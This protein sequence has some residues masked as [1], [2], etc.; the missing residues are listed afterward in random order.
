MID[1]TTRPEPCHLA[2][3]ALCW[4]RAGGDVLQGAVNAGQLYGADSRAAQYLQTR[5]ASAAGSTTNWGAELAR[6]PA[7]ESTQLIELARRFSGFEQMFGFMRRVDFNA[8][9]AAERVGPVVSWTG[10]AVPKAFS[11]MALETLTGLKPLKLSGGVVHTAELQRSSPTAEAGAARA[12]RN[13][14]AETEDAAFFGTAAAVSGVSAAGI[15][16]GV[17]GIA[18]TDDPAEDIAVLLANFGGDLRTAFLVMPPNIA[19]QLA[20]RGGIFADV[21][22]RG[23]GVIGGLPVIVT[24]G[25]TNDTSG[26]SIGLV[27]AARVCVA[28]S[29]VFIDMSREGALEMT[30]ATTNPPVAATVLVSLWQHNL[31]GLKVERFINWQ[32]ASDDAVALI[33]GASYGSAPAAFAQ[34]VTAGPA[35]RVSEAQ[36][37]A[38]KKGKPAPGR[39]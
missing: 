33:T 2:R 29:D 17:T 16:S 18:S 1:L 20:L 28:A 31:I 13:T 6:P 15:F 3:V 39:K 8:V 4:G 25:I 38:A 21:S 7:V 32:L 36:V 10:E 22:V 23:G 30:D 5:A 14:L 37:A 26:G 11:E 19:G 9:M 24:A 35:S 27:D 34:S 12:L